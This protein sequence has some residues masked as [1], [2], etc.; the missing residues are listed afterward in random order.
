MGI[1]VVLYLAYS[2]DYMTIFISQIHTP[3]KC[4]FYYMSINFKKWIKGTWNL[5]AK[6]EELGQVVAVFRI[7]VR[8]TVKVNDME[9]HWREAWEW[10][11][12]G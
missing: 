8:V 7:G 12:N 6:G 9:Q 10:A 1:R 11:R 3:K 4:E 5:G 2:N